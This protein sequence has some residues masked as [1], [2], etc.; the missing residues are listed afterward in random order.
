MIMTTILRSNSGECPL[1]GVCRICAWVVR[2]KREK[3]MEFSAG[4]SAPLL[5]M[6]NYHYTSKSRNTSLC[7]AKM[8]FHARFIQSS[9]RKSQR[10]YSGNLFTDLRLSRQLVFCDHKGQ[11]LPQYLKFFWA[12]NPVQFIPE[13]RLFGAFFLFVHPHH[14]SSFCPG[15]N[16]SCLRQLV[17]AFLCLR[18]IFCLTYFIS[19]VLIDSRQEVK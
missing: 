7:F 17:K 18:H 14:L 4:L 9:S 5:K 11:I 6:Q 3:C 12:K 15:H 16:I 13:R 8:R 19:C 10:T 1:W 2:G